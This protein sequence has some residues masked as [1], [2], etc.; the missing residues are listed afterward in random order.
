MDFTTI[1]RPNFTLAM[2]PEDG[3]R[4]GGK[5]YRPNKRRMA[6]LAEARQVLDHLP[7]PGEALCA[8]KTGR[9]DLMHLILVLLEVVPVPCGVMR[10]AT[11]SFNLRNLTEILA[12]LDSG[13]V[14]AFRMVCSSF[15]KQNSKEVYEESL[16]ELSK[17]G[18]KLVAMRSHAKLVTMAFGDG[19]RLALEGSANLRRN[20]NQEQFTLVNG[21]ELHEFHANWIDEACAKHEVHESRS[22]A[23]G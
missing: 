10:I 23:A 22:D 13:R 18:A 1:A 11:L 15:F 6:M 16:Q 12:L 5:T 20:S 21:P 7:Q 4:A 2:Q 19:T 8:M 14:K 17:R 3:R 9:Y